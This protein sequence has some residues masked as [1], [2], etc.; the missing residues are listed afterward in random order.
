MTAPERLDGWLVGSVMLHAG[1]FAMVLFSPGLFPSQ[2]AENWGSASVGDSMNV[3]IVGS[4]SRIPLPSPEVTNDTAAANESKGFYE[5]KPE[6]P[7]APEPDEKAVALPEKNAPVKTVPKKT[8]PAPKSKSNP[9]PPPPVN[10]VPFGQGGN[11][12]VGGGGQATQIGPVGAGFGDAAFGVKYSDYVQAMIRKISQNWLKGL[13][14]SRITR[15]P[16][17]YVSFE[18]ARDGSI[19]NVAITETSGYPSLDNSAKRAIFASNK[20]PPLPRD[21]LGSTVNVNFYFE[22]VKQ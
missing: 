18:I 13:V 15:A 22:Y 12:S 8:P 7:P 10:A 4:L 21:Y 5:S 3:K 20:L 11:P 17:V 9:A 16:R 6:P 14:D 2:A 19:S 1:F